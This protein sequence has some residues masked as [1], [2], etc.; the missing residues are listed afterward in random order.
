[1]AF[2]KSCALEKE[3]HIWTRGGGGE[4]GFYVAFL[5]R[6]QFEGSCQAHEC[7]DLFSFFFFFFQT[8]VSLGWHRAFISRMST[9]KPTH[10]SPQRAKV[11]ESVVWVCNR[12]SLEKTTKKTQQKSTTANGELFS[13]SAFDLI[14]YFCV[15]GEFSG[16]FVQ[17]F[18]RG[19][20][21]G[22]VKR[23]IGSY[24]CCL[25]GVVHLF[26]TFNFHAR[27]NLPLRISMYLMF[28]VAATTTTAHFLLIFISSSSSR[29]SFLFYFLFTF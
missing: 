12:R 4:D 10:L 9:R 15:V 2:K 6:I 27:S 28:K 22:G 5:W 23:H 20:K 17:I 11:K 7:S 24:H 26:N 14:I 19:A 16:G 29:L 8:L 25:F 13:S 18:R 1:M 21:V 3:G